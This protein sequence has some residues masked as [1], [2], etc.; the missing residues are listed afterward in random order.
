MRCDCIRA[1]QNDL[2]TEVYEGIHE[3]VLKGD[4][5]GNATGKV[6]VP[7]SLIGSPR[8]MI[9]NYQDAYMQDLWE[10]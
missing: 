7:S 6:I 3:A 8:Y 5:D 2:R 10:S 4:V 1:N 9:N